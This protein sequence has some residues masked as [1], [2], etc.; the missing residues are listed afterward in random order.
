ME[1]PIC[2]IQN[3]DLSRPLNLS[4]FSITHANNKIA[5]IMYS[6]NANQITINQMALTKNC[7]DGESGTFTNKIV[8][9]IDGIAISPY[10]GTTPVENTSTGVQVIKSK[11]MTPYFDIKENQTIEFNYGN[12]FIVEVDMQENKIIKENF[13]KS[14]C[15]ASIFRNPTRKTSRYI[16]P[17]NAVNTDPKN[18]TSNT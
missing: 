9:S 6:L 3:N 14:P 1:N 5:D 12:N 11:K 15:K 18:I 7:S 13:L 8:A 2:D 4:Y 16:L 17:I 10:E